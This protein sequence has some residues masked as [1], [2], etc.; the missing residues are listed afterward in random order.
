MILMHFGGFSVP[1]TSEIAR[2]MA[3]FLSADMTETP[4][5]GTKGVLRS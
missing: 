5:S 4:H 1:S 3:R 2:A